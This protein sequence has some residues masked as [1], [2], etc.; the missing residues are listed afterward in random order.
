[1]HVARLSL[2]PKEYVIIGIDPGIG[3]T[4]GSKFP[5]QIRNIAISQGSPKG[6]SKK[7]EKAL[8]KLKS[9]AR[10]DHQFLTGQKKVDMVIVGHLENHISSVKLVSIP[11][12]ATVQQQQ[13]KARTLLVSIQQYVVPVVRVFKHLQ[14]LYRG[15]PFMMKTRI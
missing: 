13:E 6:T 14:Q 10:F 2:G 8:A 7:Y 5:S 11:S 3:N 1:M 9:K 4:L 15:R 12:D